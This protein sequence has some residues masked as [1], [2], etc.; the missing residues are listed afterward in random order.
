[1]KELTLIKMTS[2]P[3]KK[4]LKCEGGRAAT[5]LGVSGA[6]PSASA[7]AARRV[8]VWRTRRL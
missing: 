1:M 8:R 2:F 3:K 6:G 4:I 7:Q 5:D